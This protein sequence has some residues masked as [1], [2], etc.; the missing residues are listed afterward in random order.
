MSTSDSKDIQANIGAA[1]EVVRQTYFNLEK[2]FRQ[3]D[4]AAGK[5]SYTTL[6]QYKPG[7]MRWKSD[8]DPWGWHVWNFIKLYRHKLNGEAASEAPS[9]A[10]QILGIEVDFQELKGPVVRTIR[11]EYEANSV[12]EDN[13]SLSLHWQYYWPMRSNTDFTINELGQN[14]IWTAVPKND[15]VKTKYK[16][17]VKATWKTRDLM[18]ITQVDVESLVRG[19]EEEW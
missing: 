15:V 18:G 10:P 14:G 16:G 13:I 7:F 12:I 17:L 1:F 2:F 19:F 4:E 3:L 8:V 6:V 11:Y 9:T 5:K